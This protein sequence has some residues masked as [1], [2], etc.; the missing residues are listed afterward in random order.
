[1]SVFGP[2]IL[3]QVEIPGFQRSA[4]DLGFMRTCE[5]IVGNLLQSLLGLVD[6][7]SRS[8]I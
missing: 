4:K 3:Q 5:E 1:M 8:M 6:A 7:P 2:G